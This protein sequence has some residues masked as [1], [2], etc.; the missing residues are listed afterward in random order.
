MPTV[1]VARAVELI[2]YGAA[3]MIGGFMGV[4]TPDRLIDEIV[5][6][7]KRDSTVSLTF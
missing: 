6:R 2:P 4:G 1:Q 3:L 7:G 5:R